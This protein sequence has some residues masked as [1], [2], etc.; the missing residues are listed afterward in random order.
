[1]R[2]TSWISDLILVSLDAK[3]H[4]TAPPARFTEASLIKDLEEAGIG[5]PSTYAP[6]IATIQRRGYVFRQGKALVPSFT[7]FAVTHLLREH[8]GDYVDIGFTAEMEDTSTRSRTASTTGWISSRRSI[9][10]TASTPA[11]RPSCRARNSRSTTR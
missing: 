11:S 4:E 10:A 1:M 6:T 5:R 2:P 8:F 3:G 9:A 7:A